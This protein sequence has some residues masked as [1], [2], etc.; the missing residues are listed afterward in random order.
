[1]E[2]SDD[3]Y[4]DIAQAYAAAAEKA[5]GLKSRF[6]AAG[7]DPAAVTSVAD[8]SRL[9]VMK[10]EELLK[11]QRENPPF[12]GFLASDLKDIGRIYVSPGPIFEP[13]L[14]GEGGHGLDLLFKA[15]GVGPGD[16]ILNTWM[17]HLVPAGLLFDEA[18]QA[19]GATVIPGGVGNTELQAQI[20]V[21]TGVTS[22]CA[23]TAFF[24]TLADKVIE[25]YGR[26]AWKVK[27]AFLGGEMGDWMAKRRRIEAEY[28]VSTWAAY[29]TAD[30][31]L[32]AYEDG[33]EGYL[34][35]PDR[36]VQICDPVS[37]EQVAHG[38][39]GEVVVTARDATWP[40]I[41]FGT[42]DSAF[43]LE[44]NA[45]GTVS[46]ISALQGRVGAAVK[47][48]EIF[49]YPRVVEEVVIGTPGAK[50]AQAVVTRENDRDMIRLSLVLED[51]ADASAAE[52]AAAKNF[53]LHTRIRVDEVNIV[54]ELPE[55]AELIVNQKD[56]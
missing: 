38:E 35:H 37:G 5:P 9:P 48:R 40:M 45:D 3:I 17:Y 49:V 41:R 43:A 24:L 30:L 12:G 18:A 27:T 42:G 39:P 53:K 14:S 2:M 11:I 34:V 44:S 16:I 25:T 13:A 19:A 23:S 7:F 21:E 1:M 10:K 15:A 22:I 31:G 36:V 29:A 4:K 8:L 20:I 47:V 32:V 56:R 28:G 33:G 55:N 54:S 6:T 52:A 26:D 46:R 50:A 51:G